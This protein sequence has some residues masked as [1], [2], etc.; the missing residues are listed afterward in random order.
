MYN[1]QCTTTKKVIAQILAIPFVGASFFFIH[2]RTLISNDMKAQPKKTRAC[3]CD[4]C[5]FSAL[6]SKPRAFRLYVREV[7]FTS[8]GQRTPPIRIN[9]IVTAKATW[10]WRTLKCVPEPKPEPKPK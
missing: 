2:C 6:K 1:V 10:R 4:A 8:S 3:I 7:A 9:A 5:G